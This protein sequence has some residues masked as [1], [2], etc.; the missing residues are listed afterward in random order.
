MTLTYADYRSVAELLGVEPAAVAAVASVESN[1][2]GFDPEGFPVTLFE[3]HWFYKLTGGRFAQT[4][5]TLCYPKWTKQYYGRSWREEK[6]RLSM[7]VTLDREAALQSASWGA[8]QIMG[9]N[10]K[11]CGCTSV[12]QFV[13]GQC[14]G[15]GEQ[16]QL[17]ARFIISANLAEPLRY[18]D[19]A[20]FAR[21]YNGPGYAA[22]RYDVKLE[23]AYNKFRVSLRAD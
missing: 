23:A 20:A 6:A 22:N 17:F 8:F 16:L 12:Q 14:A 7:A 9:F 5:P 11:A 2:G 4:H 15:L 13:N 1:N 18:H 19:W 21:G 10:Y 3:G